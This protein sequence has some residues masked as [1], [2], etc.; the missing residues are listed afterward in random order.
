MPPYKVLVVDDSA[1]MRK[2]IS[3]IIAEDKQFIVVHA[4]KNGREAVEKVKEL[5]PDVITMDVQMP[6]M[7]GIEALKIIMREFP[8]PTI[9]LSSLAD[10]GAKET[11]NALELGAVDFV[12]KPSGSISI[13][14][15]KIK[16]ILQE[17]LKAAAKSNLKSVKLK[18]RPAISQ[19]IL[20]TAALEKTKLLKEE[21]STLFQ[22]L[23]AIG[24]STGGPRA[25]QSVLPY[26]PESFPAPILVVQHMPPNFTKSLAI[27]LD[28]IS[29]IRVVEAEE[30]MPVIPG[31]AYIAPGGFHMK[32]NKG[33]AGSYKISLSK[34][35]PQCGHRPS[36]DVMFNSLLPFKDLRRHIVLMT[37]MGS[38]GAKGMK[39]LLDSGAETTIAEAEETCVVYGM[40]RSAVE[41]QGATH[42]LPLFEIAGKL[43]SVVV[44]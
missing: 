16:E 14:I 10:A 34:E 15:Y 24:T 35:E 44:N 1:F 22:H 41:L 39:A 23:V 13:D 31:T 29:R 33:P 11:I 18:F 2:L 12:R 21:R 37:G 43:T 27:R 32:L 19:P 17:K 20:K 8:T 5:R 40:P 30:G 26:I 4:A 3:D 7:N 36:V 9:M 25:L 38:D 6:E 28:S 42:I